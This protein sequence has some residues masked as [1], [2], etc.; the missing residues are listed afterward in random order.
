[1]NTAT[2]IVAGVALAGCLFFYLLLRGGEQID[3]GTREV[4]GT[5]EPPDTRPAGT[6]HVTVLSEYEEHVRREARKRRPCPTCSWPS[7]HTVGM[8]CQTCGTDYSGD[9][10]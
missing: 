4:F 2:Y 9:A 8:V 6:S 7:R 1:M 3:R 5:T 10:S